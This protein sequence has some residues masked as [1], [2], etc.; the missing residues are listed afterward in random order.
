MF[1]HPN[2]NIL[3]KL[4][5][6]HTD[7]TSAKSWQSFWNPLRHACRYCEC[8]PQCICMSLLQHLCPSR[9]SGVRICP[10]LQYTEPGA[11]EQTVDRKSTRLNSS[12]VAISYAV[13][14]L[15]KKNILCGVLVR[16]TVYHID[17]FTSHSVS[18]SSLCIYRLYGWNHFE[19]ETMANIYSGREVC[20]HIPFLYAPNSREIACIHIQVY[21]IKA[22]RVSIVCPL[23]SG[24]IAWTTY[25]LVHELR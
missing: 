18:V 4:S 17:R 21:Y 13:F 10:C 23:L 22:S 11:T 6:S 25:L 15:K 9:L 20:K 24:I 5:A 16:S 8:Q 19:E 1:H 3:S 2:K 7:L 12:H 14:C